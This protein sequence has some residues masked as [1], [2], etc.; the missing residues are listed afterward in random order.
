MSVPGCKPTSASGAC[1]VEAAL[2]QPSNFRLSQRLH[3]PFTRGNLSFADLFPCVF[4]HR[5]PFKPARPRR[6]TMRDEALV[7]M[8]DVAAID[9][10]DDLLVDIYVAMEVGPMRDD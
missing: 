10:I 9:F 6:F 4:W 7:A 3:G 2:E 8:G 1:P 5:R